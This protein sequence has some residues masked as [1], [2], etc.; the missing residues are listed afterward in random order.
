MI[1]VEWTVVVDRRAI[2]DYSIHAIVV[3]LVVVVGLT[4]ELVVGMI[5][6]MMVLADAMAVVFAHGIADNW[7]NVDDDLNADLVQIRVIPKPLLMLY[8]NDAM[9]LGLVSVVVHGILERWAVGNSECAFPMGIVD[10]VVWRH[11]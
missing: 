2:D 4:N 8:P 7:Y 9:E 11:F 5:V 6:G 3:D 1:I 10:L